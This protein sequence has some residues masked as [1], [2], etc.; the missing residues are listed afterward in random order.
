MMLNWLEASVLFLGNSSVFE[1][2]KGVVSPSYSALFPPPLLVSQEE[3]RDTQILSPPT[4]VVYC[5]LLSVS[6]TATAPSP[7]LYTRKRSLLPLRSNRDGSN[8]SLFSSVCFLSSP[9]LVQLE[10]G[11]VGL[12]EWRSS[13][14]P[15]AV[16]ESDRRG[17]RRSLL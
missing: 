4:A 11:N 2:V 8:I 3:Y 14:P 9:S 1:R 5:R 16:R 15:L 17:Q 12:D 7:L 13:L 6:E 10:L